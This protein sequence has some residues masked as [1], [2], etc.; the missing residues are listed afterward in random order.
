MSVAFRPRAL[1][2]LWAAALAVTLAACSPSG[3]GS[4]SPSPSVAPQTSAVVTP[5]AVEVTAE[6]S[7]TPS[8]PARVPDDPTWTPNQ[9]AAV[10]GIDA[11]IEVQTT[12][13]HDPANANFGDL[14]RVAT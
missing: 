1:A 2:A 6:P 5:S 14:L 9:L 13:W 7:P 4:P 11:Y 3:G 10:H 8:W 12:M